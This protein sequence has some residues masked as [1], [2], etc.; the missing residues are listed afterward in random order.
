[1][2][3]I[4]LCLIV[5]LSADF[6]VAAAAQAQSYYIS[7]EI[8]VTLRSGPTSR[9]RV[10]GK[11]PAGTPIEVL[12]SDAENKTSQVRAQDG[13]TGWISSEFISTDKTIRAL[14]QE[15]QTENN[16]LKQRINRYEQQVSDNDNIIQLN[17]Q[18]Q[19]QVSELQNEAD[20]LRQQNSLLTGRFRQEVFYAGAL[21]LLAGMLLSWI[22]SRFSNNRRQRSGWR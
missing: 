11:L 17:N 22:I 15:L 14:Y 3:R 16:N 2:L 21:V 12:S 10:T 18:L 9:Y 20:N 8:G 19:Q 7:E 13:K 1:M 5:L 4:T 6:A